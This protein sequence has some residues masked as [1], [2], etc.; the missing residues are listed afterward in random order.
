MKKNTILFISHRGERHQQAAI[1]AAP[2]TFEVT[3]KR[4]PSKEEIIALLPGKE[5][6][7]SERTGDIDADII[8]AGKDLR[9]IQR[10]GSQ[11]FDID[12]GAAKNAGI[13]VCSWPVRTCVMVAEHM[14]LQMLGL[15]KRLRENMKITTDADDW[16]SPPQRSDEDTFAYNW[17]KRE[18]LLGLYESTVGIVGFGEIGTELSR[19]LQHFECSVLYNKRSQLPASFEGDL[20]IQYTDLDDLLARSD[21]V[22]MLLPYF[23]ETD[24]IVNAGFIDKMKDGACLV[25]CGG[26]GILDEN[27]VSSALTSKKLYGVA[28]DTF[29]WEPVHPDSPLLPLARLEDAN[30]ILTPHTAAGTTAANVNERENDYTNLVNFL[31]NKPLRFRLV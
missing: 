10:L 26:S 23:P 2:D 27:A 22:C 1:N 6:L 31:N 11:T 7:I 16:G 18:N 8:A 30:V 12:L 17:S 19:R 29:E 24:K 28:T 25:S 9:L 5:F 3:M 14:V 15:A 13:P 20:G 21:F 4:S